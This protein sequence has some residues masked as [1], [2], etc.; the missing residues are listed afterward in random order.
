M[1]RTDVVAN[2]TRHNQI[3]SV[4]NDDTKDVKLLKV[5]GKFRMGDIATSQGVW[6][7]AYTT[8]ALQFILSRTGHIAPSARFYVVD[9]GSKHKKRS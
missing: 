5:E 7:F 4:L 6:R 9:N 8:Y 3:I 1:V 2:N